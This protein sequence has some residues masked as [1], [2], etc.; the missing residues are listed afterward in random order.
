MKN[1][2]RQIHSILWCQEDQLDQVEDQLARE[3][4]IQIQ[5]PIWD[6]NWWRVESQILNQVEFNLHFKT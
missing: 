6:Q 1:L 3:I 5:V 2:K 4:N